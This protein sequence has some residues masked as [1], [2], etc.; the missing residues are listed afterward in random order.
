M[1]G[2]VGS[3]RKRSGRKSAPTADWRLE[4]MP[5]H[6]DERRLEQGISCSGRGNERGVWGR[7]RN[8]R[9]KGVHFFPLFLKQTR[10]SRLP[11][12]DPTTLSR[13]THS[14]EVRSSAHEQRNGR[15]ST[16]I[17]ID[18]QQISPITPRAEIPSSVPIP[19]RGRYLLVRRFAQIQ[20]IEIVAWRVPR[21]CGARL[22]REC[23]R[24]CDERLERESSSS[25]GNLRHER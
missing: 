9:T 19:L 13:L 6:L 15:S 22:A 7:E 3:T 16:I 18:S 23:W 10:N 4:F 2:G 8:A 11:F 25:G 1:C 12:R 20:C 21:R 17:K 14:C 5:P 24:R